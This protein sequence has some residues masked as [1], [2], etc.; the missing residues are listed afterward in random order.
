MRALQ[1]RVEYLEH[2]FSTARVLPSPPSDPTT[3]SI[4]ASTPIST[5]GFSPVAHSIET[6]RRTS[7]ISNPVVEINNTLPTVGLS[8]TISHFGNLANYP[9]PQAFMLLEYDDSED[10]I[11]SEF[12]ANEL[13]FKCGKQLKQEIGL[14]LDPEACWAHQRSFVRNILPWFPLFSERDCVQHMESA[15]ANN[16]S[17]ACSSTALAY[18]ILALGA[19]SKA[20]HVRGDDPRDFPGLQYFAAARELPELPGITHAMDVVQSQILRT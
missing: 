9:R 8:L 12:H 13:I 11:E 15:A 10:Y 17:P 2:A 7:S 18:Y 20:D 6:P 4:A 3:S 16:F 5:Q 19:F 1:A 14:N